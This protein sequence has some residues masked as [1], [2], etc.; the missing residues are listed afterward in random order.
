MDISVIICT[1]NRAESLRRTL[2]TFLAI[3]LPAG[4]AWELLVVDNN[5]TDKTAGACQDLAARLPLRYIVERQQGQNHA[6]RRG[7]A[8][9]KAELLLF[10]DDDVDVERH[11]VSEIFA[12]ARKNPQISFF[13]GKVLSRWQTQPPRWFQKNIEMIRCVPRVNLGDEEITFSKPG[14]GRLI[15]AN[16]AM[17]KA[18]L[19]E[20]TF[21]LDVGPR[22]DGSA[23]GN[24]GPG[25]LD[26]EERLLAKGHRG[27]YVPR[28]VIYHRDPPSR[29]TEK[30]LRHWYCESGRLLVRTGERYP[31]TAHLFNAPRYLWREVFENA[32]K[33]AFGRW[34]ASSRFWLSAE[35]RMCVAWG[36]IKEY[37]TLARKKD[38]KQ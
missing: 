4:F 10:T 2:E 35:C 21:R 31:A 28:A 7:I 14:E 13:G 30:Y 20:E 5:S 38:G 34:L 29:M 25:E 24:V 16:L 11:W 19:A 3:E 22:G 27:L 12:A 8:E 6:L 26:L 17:R 18:A 36:K 33:Y 37:Q 1:Y 32:L 9:A 23:G 15:G